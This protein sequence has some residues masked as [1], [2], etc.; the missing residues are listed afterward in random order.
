MQNFS[1]IFFVFGL[2]LDLSLRL[3]KSYFAFHLIAKIEVISKHVIRQMFK[4][5][6]FLS[7]S[8]DLSKK[9]DMTQYYVEE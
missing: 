7:E 2:L 9:T 6:I 1:A 4:K 3:V 8:V 5:G